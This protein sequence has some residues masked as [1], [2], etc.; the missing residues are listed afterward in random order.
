[1]VA[2]VLGLV[3]LRLLVRSGVRDVAP[4]ADHGGGPE[5][6][7]GPCSPARGQ[8]PEDARL[9]RS[10]SARTSRISVD[11]AHW[12]VAGIVGVL[13]SES[14]SKLRDAP[15]PDLSYGP[16]E[17]SHRIPLG[18]SLSSVI[19]RYRAMLRTGVM[20]LLSI[21]LTTIGV[22][23]IAAQDATAE[24]STRAS[25]SSS[26]SPSPSDGAS[27]S[28]VP[29][30]KATA[31][32][33]A[34]QNDVAGA[35]PAP[36]E[37]AAPQN[38]APATDIP[39]I[40]DLTGK[41]HWVAEGGRWRW[42]NDDGTIA[43]SQW[44]RIDGRVYR[45]DDNGYMQAGWWQSDQS[46]YYLYP[47]GAM[48]TG[49]IQLNGNWYYLYPSGAMATGWIQQSGNWYYL[50]PSGIMAT[51]T[52]A[53]GGTQYSFS[54]NGVWIG[55]QAPA[56]YLQPV[57]TIT[58]PG[59]ATNSLTMGMNGVKVRIVQQR[60]GLWY[61]TKLAS[62]DAGLQAAVRN[63]QRRAGLPQT[64]VV[65]ETTWN[66]LDTGYSWWVDQYQETPVSLSATRDE[67]IETMIGYAWGQVGSSYTWGGAGPYSLGYDCSGLV[68]QSLYR[69]GLDP[70]PINV[71]KHAW[72]DYRTSQELY[73]HPRMMHVPLS[74]RRRGDLIFYTTDGVVTHVAIYLGGDQVIH[75][76]WMG[77]P[78]RV[79]HITTSYGWGNMTADIVRPFPRPERLGRP[80][81]FW[82][83]RGVRGNRQ[84]TTGQCGMHS[85]SCTWASVRASTSCWY[86]GFASGVRPILMSCSA[87]ASSWNS[88][89]SPLESRALVEV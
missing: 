44:A 5:P 68:L 70:Q 62:V 20:L 60:L 56:G 71:I 86:S 50:Y 21:A 37:E 25:E 34:P 88:G 59:W 48:A 10:G 39:S 74:Q 63:F 69:A 24:P 43:H 3:P 87:C 18:G 64:G 27:T 66:A 80:G 8:T 42:R 67:R 45:F 83:A 61:S 75:T 7:P 33:P 32:D 79:D 82:V 14:W 16:V 35:A 53:I 51:G 57:P 85:L 49:W 73:R 13:L 29:Q 11:T 6:R 89:T 65:D 58:S 41:G 72:P 19:T 22:P 12:F 28:A 26:L 38:S 23:A 52:Q 1:M 76:D 78:A 77:R 2:T 81:S 40:N 54:P 47:S 46:W 30:E 84:K 4:R 36:Q 17:T 31:A 9:A 55:Y 15:R